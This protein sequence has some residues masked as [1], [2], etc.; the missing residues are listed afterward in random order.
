MTGM[1]EDGAQ[2]LGLMKTSGA[3]TI[4]Q[5]EQSCVVF[6]M[7][8]VAI[9]RGFAQRVVEL[10]AMAATLQAQCG[11]GGAQVARAAGKN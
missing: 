1:G 9:E 3:M 11:R 4:A 2:G 10:D 5:G 8:K 6:G 7:P